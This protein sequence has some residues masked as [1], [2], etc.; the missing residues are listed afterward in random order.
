MGDLIWLHFP[1]VY[2]DNNPQAR[3]PEW[4]NCVAPALQAVWAGLPGCH[5]IHVY[6]FFTRTS[7]IFF[8]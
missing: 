5:F 1:P 7:G 3:F 4:R 8:I 6:V 2:I